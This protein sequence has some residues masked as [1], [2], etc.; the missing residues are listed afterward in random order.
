MKV[1][2]ILIQPPSLAAQLEGK[3][4]TAISEKIK[5]TTAEIKTTKTEID[6]N[7]DSQSLIDLLV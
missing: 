6:I 2:S 1:T 3:S 4:N 5:E 7:T